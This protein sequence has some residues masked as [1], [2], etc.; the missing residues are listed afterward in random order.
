MTNQEIE[1]LKW[2]FDYNL[3]QISLADNKEEQLKNLKRYLTTLTISKSANLQE[4]LPKKK[5]KNNLKKF[6]KD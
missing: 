6:K 5:L 2:Q 3:K 1:F 4:K